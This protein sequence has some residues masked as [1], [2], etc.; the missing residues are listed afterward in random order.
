MAKHI[1][2]QAIRSNHL[3]QAIRINQKYNLMGEFSMLQN[4]GG[5]WVYSIRVL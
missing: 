2:G 4:L 5:I 1:L 3:E